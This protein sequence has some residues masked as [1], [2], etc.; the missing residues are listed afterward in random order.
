MGPTSIFP[1][2]RIYKFPW[3]FLLFASSP[4]LTVFAELL[5]QHLLLTMSMRPPKFLHITEVR[6]SKFY[7]RIKPSNCASEM[8][9]YIAALESADGDHFKVPN[10]VLENLKS[11]E[12]T[13]VS[14][15]AFLIGVVQLLLSPQEKLRR[16]NLRSMLNVYT[17]RK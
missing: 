9:A 15:S 8:L 7:Q 2:G 17:R 11:C 1:V 5:R 6:L 14:L 10:V 12:D 4:P 16:M 13:A 3:W